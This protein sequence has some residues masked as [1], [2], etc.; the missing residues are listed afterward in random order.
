MQ[1][2]TNV[3]WNTSMG[4]YDCQWHLREMARWRKCFTTGYRL[5]ASRLARAQSNWRDGLSLSNAGVERAVAAMT[6][7]WRVAAC[8]P[9]SVSAVIGMQVATDRGCILML[10]YSAGTGIVS[11]VRVLLKDRVRLRDECVRCAG[12]KPELQPWSW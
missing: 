11:S 7:M 12:P 3:P 1:A 5:Q 10:T 6:S 2:H 9:C 4:F 8:R